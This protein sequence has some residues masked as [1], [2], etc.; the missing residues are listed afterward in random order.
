[1][2][3]EAIDFAVWIANNWFIPSNVGGMWKLDKNDENFTLTV[4]EA[5]DNLFSTEQLYKWFRNKSGEF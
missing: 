2:E 4:K 1:M 3:N 5:I